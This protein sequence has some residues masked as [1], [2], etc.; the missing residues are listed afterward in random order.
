VSK[1][2]LTELAKRMP[3][4]S[5]EMKSLYVGGVVYFD[6]NG[7]RLG[8][9]G[10][11]D[12]IRVTTLEDY[13]IAYQLPLNDSSCE[14]MGSPLS[15][16]SSEG[17]QKIYSYYVNSYAPNASS[18]EFGEISDIA[19]CDTNGKLTLNP[20]ASGVGNENSL[21]STLQHE[22]YHLRTISD[23][24]SSGDNSESGIISDYTR[25][26]ENELAAL[27]YQINQQEFKDSS[28]NYKSQIAESIYQTW[29]NLGMYD[30]T[31]E[32]A[33]ALCNVNYTIPE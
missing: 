2:S 21:I 10:A 5:E 9:V 33:M 23:W 8:K 25:K 20:F 30:K 17:K 15:S 18:F 22:D 7:N 1:D 32:D 11:S 14:E 4:L 26:K 29:S 6:E 31:R 3:V 13:E 16:I 27:M 28:S 19:Q 24:Q 12:S